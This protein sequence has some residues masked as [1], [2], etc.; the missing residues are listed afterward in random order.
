MNA[1]KLRVGDDVYYPDVIV[2]CSAAD[3]DDRWVREPCL[4][5]E[6]T[7]PST[8][9]FDRLEK[10]NAYRKIPPLQAYL[11]VEQAWRRV[12]R[13]WRD[14]AR[15]WQQEDLQGEGAISLSCPE[16]LLTL[17]Q[18]YEGLAPLTAN[19]LEAIG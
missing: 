1:I 3:Q 15:V 5:I 10:L 14:A 11:I 18:I 13:H 7:S 2:T 4:L 19:E 8:A 17:D 9:R 6:A 16:V 12:V